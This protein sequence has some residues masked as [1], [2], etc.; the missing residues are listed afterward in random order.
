MSDQQSSKKLRE[1]I[2]KKFKKR[3]VHSSFADTIWAADLADI[4]L[5]GKFNKLFT[6]S[7]CVIDIYSNMQV[8]NMTFIVIYAR[9]IQLK[10]QKGFTITNTFQKNF[11]RI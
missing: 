4:Q 1:P 9:T 5:I 6:F 10:D 7:L 11:R 3:K 8:S 2:I